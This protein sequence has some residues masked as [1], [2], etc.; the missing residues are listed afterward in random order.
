MALLAMAM[1]IAFAAC[2][3][4]DSYSAG[5]EVSGDCPSVYF[6]SDNNNI[7]V[8]DLGD[9]GPGEITL[10]VEREQTAGA[11]TAPLVVDKNNASFSIPESVSFNDGEKE[12]SLVVKYDE[13]VSGMSF[14]VRIAD[15]YANPYTEKD[16]S[17]VFSLTVT[18]PYE[19]C[20][21]TYSND[22]T[23]S[24][25]TVVSGR[26]HGVTDSKIYAYSGLNKFLWTDFFGSGVDVAFTV[27]T[28]NS[29]GT[30]D[31]S[32]LTKLNGDI[33]PLDHYTANEYGYSL[34]TETGTDDYVTWTPAGSSDEIT[35]YFYGYYSGHY[36]YIDFEPGG[37]DDT[38]YGY[39][40]SCYVYNGYENVYFYLHYT[41]E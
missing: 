25:G 30:F 2:G 21:V 12:A 34:V 31:S 3:D 23:Y 41:E 37:N 5:P 7:C 11:L 24:S 39:L 13:Y 1:P 40:W 33:V 6:S 4:D 22:T 32:D 15:E 36:S 28:S 16:G 38:G 18:Q 8:V 10:K 9:N 26:F 29:T 27:D 35:L 14:T 20:T 19:L 17:Y